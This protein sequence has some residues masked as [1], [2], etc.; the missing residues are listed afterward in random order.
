[1]RCRAGSGPPRHPVRVNQKQKATQ[2]AAAESKRR[3]MRLGAFL[4]HRQAPSIWSSTSERQ[5][6]RCSSVVTISLDTRVAALCFVAGKY[7]IFPDVDI[8][9][10]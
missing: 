4:A 2:K 8:L 7:T 9:D 1:M 10:T 6:S 5:S 3:G